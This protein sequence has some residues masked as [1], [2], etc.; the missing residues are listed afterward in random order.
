MVDRL[1]KKKSIAVI[2]GGIFGALNA[3]KLNESGHDVTIIERGQELLN[4]ASFN[5]QNRLH[6]GFHY[7]RDN[8]T[9]RQ[10]MRGYNSFKKR[11]KSSILSNFKN[12][13]FI[14]RE[15]SKTSPEEYI[16]F[17]NRHA[18]SYKHIELKLFNPKVNN[19][20]LGL[21]C[22]ESVYDC[23]ILRKLIIE[24][25]KEQNIRILYNT[26][27]EY[28]E[29]N[30]GKYSLKTSS[31]NNLSYDIIINCTYADIN[32]LTENLFPV[33][34]KNQYEYTLVPIIKWDHDPLGITIM[35]GN[36]M[37]VLPFGRTG[38]FLLYHVEHSVIEKVND[39]QMPSEW[40]NDKT[41]PHN[42]INH[43][44]F[45]NNMVNSC[46]KFVPDLI[47]AKLVG[48]LNGS[49]IVLENKEKSDARPSIIK[50]HGEG[51]ITVFSG[52][53][54]HSIWVAD[55]IS[56]LVKSYSK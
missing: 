22:T 45:F 23:M 33:I 8:E 56:S 3:L 9:A 46:I 39:Y 52:K 10:C 50:E 41:S 17:C 51:Y 12:A 34:N 47:N 38:N 40:I 29:R 53:I 36:F 11:F 25:L 54:D 44:K 37:T 2:G 28:I 19:V 14:S 4:G 13:Y 30:N 7:P 1:S 43:R 5:N 27:V 31:K 20:D 35:D 21:L 48:F 26:Y 6:L 16:D 49:R 24:M 18:L 32:R 42:N 15:G 55:E